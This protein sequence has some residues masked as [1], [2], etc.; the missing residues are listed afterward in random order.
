MMIW[1]DSMIDMIWLIWFDDWLQSLLYSEINIISYIHCILMYFHCM[2]RSFLAIISCHCLP[3]RLTIQKYENNHAMTYQDVA[4]GK[5][6]GTGN[7]KRLLPRALCRL[8]LLDCSE[9]CFDCYLF[10]N[11]MKRMI[12]LVSL[13]NSQVISYPEQTRNWYPP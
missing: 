11:D 13:V 2:Y 6:R 12:Y 4:A 9:I 1:C 10:F 3:P 8:A 7:W 5:V